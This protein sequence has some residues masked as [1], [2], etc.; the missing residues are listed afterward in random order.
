MGAAG[1]FADDLV[2]AGFWGVAGAF[3]DETGAGIG[4]ESRFI[5]VLVRV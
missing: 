3:T 1:T 4:Q 5:L 2:F